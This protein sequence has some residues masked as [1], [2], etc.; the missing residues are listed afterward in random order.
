MHVTKQT[1][2]LPLKSA[3][4]KACALFTFCILATYTI[5]TNYSCKHQD[6]SL[7]ITFNSTGKVTTNFG[8]RSTSAARGVV[9]LPCGTIVAAGTTFIQSSFPPT[10]SPSPS[11]STL[12][13]FA[14]AGY[15]PYG[16]LDTNFGPSGTGLVITDFAEVLGFPNPSFDNA[17]GCALQTQCASC[18]IS[19]T[20]DC[21]YGCTHNYKIVVAGESNATPNGRNGFAVARYTCDG[22]LDTTF[23]TNGVTVTRLDDNLSS[24]GIAVAIQQDGKI[25]VGGY[26]IT[27]RGP[28]LFA[29]V[30][31]TCDGALDTT[32]GCNKNGIVVTDFGFDSIY[33]ADVRALAIQGNGKIILAGSSVPPGANHE[34]FTLVR[35]NSNGTIDKT[36]GNNGLVLTDFARVLGTGPISTDQIYAITILEYDDTC[37]E[38]G[39][40]L[41]IIAGGF[42]DVN[43]PLGRDFAL[44]CYNEDGSLNADF[45]PTGT[46]LA[47]TAFSNDPNTQDTIAALIAQKQCNQ[48]YTITAAGY[49]NA[50]NFRFNFALAQYLE[51]GDLN[52]NFGTNG[53]VITSFTNN[54]QAFAIASQSNGDLIAAGSTYAQAQ[55]GSIFALARYTI[56]KKTCMSSCSARI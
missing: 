44:A 35:Y 5:H 48:L 42:T 41:K 22:R 43:S 27:A 16:S 34:D 54:D 53:K 10:P 32:F 49:T 21:D 56:C 55:N 11:T 17:H 45:G 37:C 50:I 3:I 26:L 12:S 52:P 28:S 8:P 23:G 20:R 29:V 33:N 2:K 46:G 7:D 4:K 15:T 38:S 25:V 31:Y 13:N 9:A 40:P 18:N 24:S 6:G 1:I 51:S 36:F 39:K 14:L 47:I 30:R 19:C